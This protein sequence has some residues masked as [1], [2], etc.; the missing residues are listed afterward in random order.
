M[1]DI[2]AKN[3]SQVEQAEGMNQLVVLQPH[4][5]YTC[6][7]GKRARAVGQVR[8]RNRGA[9]ANAHFRVAAQILF[10]WNTALQLFNNEN[11]LDTPT[12]LSTFGGGM[13]AQFDVV[14]EAGE[15]LQSTQTAGTNAEFIVNF[16]VKELPI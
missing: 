7:V 15:T 10:G 11:Y 4:T 1:L 3:T 5:Y 9:A 2:I 12:R 8:C 6:P 13:I 16:K 14:L